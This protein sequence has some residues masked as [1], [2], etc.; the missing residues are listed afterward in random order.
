MCDGMRIIKFFFLIKKK[1]FLRMAIINNYLNDASDEN[2]RDK[3]IR[4]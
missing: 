3:K 4:L 2:Q 1:I